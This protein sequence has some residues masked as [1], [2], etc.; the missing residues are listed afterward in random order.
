MQLEVGIYPNPLPVEVPSNLENWMYY[1]GPDARHATSIGFLTR[2]A[3]CSSPE[4]P[5][6]HILDF[7]TSELRLRGVAPIVQPHMGGGDV[8]CWNG[9]V[10][11]SVNTIRVGADRTTTFSL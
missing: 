3:A 1:V 6:A 9:E 2:S 5:R 4:I 10:R 7:Y 11:Q 8:L